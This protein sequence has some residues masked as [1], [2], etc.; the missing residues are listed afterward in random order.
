MAKM[1][2]QMKE[3][4]K[5]V[6]QTRR[7]TDILIKSG[8][9]SA[10]A[11]DIAR[12]ERST[13]SIMDSIKNPKLPRDFSSEM[14]TQ[15][16]D[17]KLLG[18]RKYIDMAVS[19]ARHAAHLRDDRK[20]NSWLKAARDYLPKAMMVGAGEDFRRDTLR[21]IEIVEFTGT[22]APPPEGTQAKPIDKKPP[23]AVVNRAKEPGAM[24]GLPN[25]A[26]A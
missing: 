16:R 22:V 18:Y 4:E 3:I 23:P 21:V 7:R 25:R 19:S 12:M 24:P 8:M 20:K 10:Q 13:T 26:K 2:E 5:L 11:G 1:T 6:E 15:V 17:I 9:E 14:Q